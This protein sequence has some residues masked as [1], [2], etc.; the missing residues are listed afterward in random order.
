VNGYL[1]F[2]V[3]GTFEFVYMRRQIPVA[4][5]QCRQKELEVD[6]VDADSENERE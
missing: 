1:D 4:E 2:N 3:A 6:D 5:S